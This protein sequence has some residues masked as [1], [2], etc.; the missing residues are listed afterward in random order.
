MLQKEAHHLSSCVRPS[1]ICVCPGKAAA[2]PRVSGSVDLPVLEHCA[3]ALI[4]MNSSGIG[5]PSGDLTPNQLL[6]ELRTALQGD[7]MITV[8]RVHCLVLIAVKN[9]RRYRRRLL[10]NV[11]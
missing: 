9:D 5:V 8:L 6:L 2:R 10:R 1:W 3:A 11:P 7:D 4:A